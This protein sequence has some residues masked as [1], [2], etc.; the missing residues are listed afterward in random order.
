M[1]VVVNC[2]EADSAGADVPLGAVPHDG[3]DK[4][5]AVTSLGLAL[6][7]ATVVDDGSV[8]HR[9]QVVAQATWRGVGVAFLDDGESGFF[10]RLVGL[11]LIAGEACRDKV[12][13][14]KRMP[15]TGSG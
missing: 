1:L 4:L 12:G 10:G 15:P 14:L 2:M 5:L 3:L 13:L 9:L 7:L 11:Q 8:G 6:T